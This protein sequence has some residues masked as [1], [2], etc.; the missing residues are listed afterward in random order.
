MSGS[1]GLWKME[2]GAVRELWKGSEGGLVAPPAISP[3]GAQICFSA[4]KKGQ[5][6]LYL[7]NADGTNVRTLT[8]ALDVRGSASWS[9]DGKWLAVTGN[10][11]EGYR[12]FNV[13]IGAV[14]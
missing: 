12:V 9:P 2:G 4:R 14:P 10:Q 5:A 11:G 3:D 8:N 13:P 1:N 7:M 6:A